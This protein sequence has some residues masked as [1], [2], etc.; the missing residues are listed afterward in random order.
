MAEEMPRK[1]FLC[2]RVRGYRPY[3]EKSDVL[4]KRLVAS[5]EHV[6][7]EAQAQGFHY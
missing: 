4:E 5:N 3:F 2:M 6:V 7:S 1:N